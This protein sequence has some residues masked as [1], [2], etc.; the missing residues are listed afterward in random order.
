M[1]WRQAPMSFKALWYIQNTQTNRIFV[2]SSP[3]RSNLFPKWTPHRSRFSYVS[4]I[5]Y[6]REGQVRFQLKGPLTPK[7]SETARIGQYCTKSLGLF[8]VVFIKIIPNFLSIQNNLYRQG[9]VRFQFN[10]GPAS[11][12]TQLPQRASS[13]MGIKG[14]M[15][16]RSLRRVLSIFGPLS[17]VSKPTIPVN[18]YC[19]E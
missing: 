18:R 13:L 3:N 9:T 7:T 2:R 11:H 19:L 17:P 8:I 6:F 1:P 10:E 4:R 15:L 14:S 12:T 16:H 5:F